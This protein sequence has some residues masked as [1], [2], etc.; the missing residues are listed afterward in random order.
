MG[1][2]K[3]QYIQATYSSLQKHFSVR[4]MFAHYYFTSSSSVENIKI[5]IDST[6]YSVP[7]GI[8]LSGS[9]NPSSS[10]GGSAIETMVDQSYTHTTTALTL[11]ISTSNPNSNSVLWGIREVFVIIKLCNS[12]CSGCT[13]YTSDTCTSCSESNRVANYAGYNG[14]CVCYGSGIY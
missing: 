1:R 14:T 12:S 8:S 9:N 2:A 4:V 5:K 13:G 11:Q 3:N 7:I 6:T 10:C